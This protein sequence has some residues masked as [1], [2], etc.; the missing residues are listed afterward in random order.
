MEKLKIGNWVR[1]KSPQGN[2]SIQ[3]GVVQRVKRRKAKVRF[4]G[5]KGREE[6]CLE[7][8]SRIPRPCLLKK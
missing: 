6:V 1:R 2:L 4:H 8:L 3:T 7:I 5:Q